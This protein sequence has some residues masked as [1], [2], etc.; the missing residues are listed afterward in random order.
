MRS[1]TGLLAWCVVAVVAVAPVLLSST[2]DADSL[3]P[4]PL[5][6]LLPSPLPSPLPTPVPTSLPAAAGGKKSDGDDDE[7]T[8]GFGLAVFL[9]IA[10]AVL[11][12]LGGTVGYLVYMSKADEDREA[13]FQSTLLGSGQAKEDIPRNL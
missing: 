8:L 1:Y 6:S 5:P 4:T 11:A 2:V 3:A 9:V 7:A 13:A 10:L 12:V